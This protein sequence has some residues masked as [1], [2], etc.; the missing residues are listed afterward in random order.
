MLQP[1]SGR[2][3]DFRTSVSSVYYAFTPRFM[4]SHD[5]GQYC[6]SESVVFQGEGISDSEESE[7]ILPERE[8]AKILVESFKEIRQVIS[9]CVQFSDDEITIWTLL[10]SHDRVARGKVYEKELDLC[11]TL[12]I[13]DFDFRVTSIDLVSPQQL[14]DVGSK[15][16]YHRQ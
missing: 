13:Y 9:I 16:I 8:I 14:I 12:R 7:W 4:L 10:D 3:S 11:Q 2:S 1:R 5:K 15:E 6:L